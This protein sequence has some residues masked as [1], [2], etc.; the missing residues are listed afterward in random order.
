MPAEKEIKS[1]FF[2]LHHIGLIV[3]DINKTIKILTSIGIGPFEI[4]PMKDLTDREFRGKR[5]RS[6]SDV[7]FA[8]LGQVNLELVQPCE[9]ESLQKETLE[10][11]GEGIEHLG[12]FVDN[13]WEEVNRLVQKGCKVVASARGPQG[14]GWAFLQGESDGGFYIELVQPWE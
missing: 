6:N 7:W 14:G 4:A 3:K 10:R 1:P 5:V 8:K 9:G 12:F 2:E 11:K 13:L